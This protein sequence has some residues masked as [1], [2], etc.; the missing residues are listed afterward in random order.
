MNTATS[1]S[2]EALRL[3]PIAETERIVAGIRDIVFRQLKRKGAVI[4]V[5]GGIDSS[6]VVFLCARALGND[7]VLA[8][9]TPE[10]ESS[11]GQSPARSISRSGFECPICSRKH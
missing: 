10:S 8:L 3:N 9:F 7:R 1:I 6:V 4:G 5:S 2:A 11:P